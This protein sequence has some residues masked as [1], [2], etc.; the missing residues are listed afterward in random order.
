M[1]VR[2]KEALEKWCPKSIVCK[3]HQIGSTPSLCGV[4]R[5]REGGPLPGTNCIGSNCMLWQW[6]RKS[7]MG[8]PKDQ[9]L[10][11]EEWTGECGLCNR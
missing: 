5:H 10:S 9:E 3:S 6:V 7:E 1:I 4:N 2:E 8:F 11:R